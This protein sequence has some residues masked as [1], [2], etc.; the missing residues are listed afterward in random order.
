MGWQPTYH[1]EGRIFARYLLETRPTAKNGVPS[2]KDDSGKDYVTAYNLATTLVRLLEQ[3]GDDLTRENVMAQAAH[4]NLELPLL[5]PGV[6][7]T[8][9]PAQFFP[10]RTM[11]LR[12]FNGTNWERLGRLV[13]AE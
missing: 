8:T 3:C 4:L 11:Q 10:I 2:P 13:T 6:R 5:L 7:V 12:R 1:D 9:G